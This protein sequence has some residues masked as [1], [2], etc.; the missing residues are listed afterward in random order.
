MI[1]VQQIKDVK[2]PPPAEFH[3][4]FGNIITID[5]RYSTAVF[6]WRDSSPAAQEGDCKPIPL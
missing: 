3:F 1:L 5:C 6:P 4:S 2:E